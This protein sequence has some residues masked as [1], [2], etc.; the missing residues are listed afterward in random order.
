MLYAARNS[1]VMRT[2]TH[3]RNTALELAYGSKVRATKKASEVMCT[4]GKAV[5]RLEFTGTKLLRCRSGFGSELVSPIESSGGLDKT[6]YEH[7]DKA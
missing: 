3:Q 5:C 2:T 1:C 4:V 6:N 7:M